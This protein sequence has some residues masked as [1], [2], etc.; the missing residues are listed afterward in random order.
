MPDQRP[1]PEVA[2]G[3]EF[4]RAGGVRLGQRPEGKPH[5][6]WRELRGGK[7][8]PSVAVAAALARELHEEL[9][10]HVRSS[11]RWSVREHSYPHARVRLHFRRVFD[12]DGE[13]VS[14]EGQAFGWTRPDAIG[15]APLLPA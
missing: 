1:L 6:G 4:D 14:R 10:T 12:W 8:Q 7:L 11:R 5:A 3:R 15:R 13:P 9:G 2:A